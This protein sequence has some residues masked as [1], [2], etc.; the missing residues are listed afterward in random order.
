MRF[1]W[2]DVSFKIKIRKIIKRKEIVTNLKRLS[3]ELLAIITEPSMGPNII[4][5]LAMLS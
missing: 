5:M 4:P 3:I 2:L 1:K